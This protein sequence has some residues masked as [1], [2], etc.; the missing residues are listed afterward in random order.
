MTTTPLD[1]AAC[2]EW[3]HAIELAPGVVTP[4]R[5]PAGTLASQW[6]ALRLPDLTG[7]SVLDV[8]AYDGF[9]SFEAERQG[10][11]RVVALDHY[12]WS[13]D[14]AAYMAEWRATR[15]T[16]QPI[17]APHASRHW[18]PATLP[19][20]R[21]FDLAHATLKSRVIP[22]VGDFATMDI[23]QLGQFDVVLFLGVLYHLTDPLD[24]MRRVA[25]LTAPGGLT[26]IET[27]A[28]EIQGREEQALCEFFPGEELNHDASNWWAPNATALEGL[29]R[30][31]GF[32]TVT[33]FTGRPRPPGW[34]KRLR[35]ALGWPNPP[36]R[37]RIIAQARHG[38]GR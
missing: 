18:S 26:V 29:C 32:E 9:F 5:V 35:T 34:R 1:L 14:M 16:G 8:G 10:A 12:V 31:A 25:Q 38:A 13:T 36:V 37:Y 22:V 21:P 7:K 33:R 2:P 24:S 28:M 19:G 11:A 15:T 23:A 27:E 20:K 17:P 6:K 3:Y 30:A 4:G